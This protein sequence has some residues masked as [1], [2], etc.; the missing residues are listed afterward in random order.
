MKHS[1][2]FIIAIA[3]VGFCFAETA[4]GALVVSIQDAQVT[5][6][7]TGFADVYLRSTDGTDMIT[8][9][10]YQFV[11]SGT[12]MGGSLGFV[13]LVDQMDASL[14]Q[15]IAGPVPYVFFGNTDAMNYGYGM[16]DLLRTVIS[17]GDA[18]GSFTN[19]PITTSPRLL[20]RVVFKDITPTPGAST[21]TYGLSVN[22]GFTDFKTAASISLPYTV[23]RLGS[24]TV[25]T[26]VP[27]PSSIAFATSLLCGLA[28]CRWRKSKHP[29]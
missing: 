21:G 10:A 17:G 5:G 20:A 24:I 23:D 26:A 9:V 27:E 1:L 6:G 29:Q 7:G 8:E 2:L 14:V 16:P 12:G 15:S 11:L 22:L 19:F 4:S 3:G 13:D 28:L 18:T 25:G